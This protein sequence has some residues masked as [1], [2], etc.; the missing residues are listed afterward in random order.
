M[1]N[2]EIKAKATARLNGH[3][4]TTVALT[5]F[6]FAFFLAWGIF[7]VIIYVAFEHHGIEY[8][9]SPSYLFGTHFGRFMMMIRV[10]VVLF[11]VNPERYILGRIFVD[12]YS[13][14]NFIETRRYIQYNSRAIH[15]RATFSMMLPMFLKLIVLSPIFI[16]IYGIYYWGWARSGEALTTAGLFIFMISIGFT[17]VWIGV[18][19]NYCISLAL[20]KYIMMLNPRGSIFDACD[21]SAKLMDGNH[22]RYILF[23]LSFLKFVPLLIFFY[24]LFLLEPYYTMCSCAFAEDIMGNYWQDKS[25]A[26]IQRWNKYAR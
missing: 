5:V 18:F 1:T 20:T 11:V 12:I 14:R 21:L 25:P 15:P 9:Y 7:E 22:T 19:I 16:S 4:G 24:P 8:G 2:K 10:L 3:R 13:G 17:L 6:K 23:K 26:M